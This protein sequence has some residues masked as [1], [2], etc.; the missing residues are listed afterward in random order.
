MTKAYGRSETTMLQ[1]LTDAYGGYDAGTLFEVIHF[2]VETYR[3]GGSYS[4]YSGT[5]ELINGEVSDVAEKV[6]GEEYFS[7]YDFSLSNATTPT[8]GRKTCRN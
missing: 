6:N 7:G 8:A 5:E 4:R 3:T 1:A 2:H